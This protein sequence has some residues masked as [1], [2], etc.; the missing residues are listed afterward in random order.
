MSGGWVITASI[1]G[2]VVLLWVALLV[3]LWAQV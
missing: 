2:G 1:V 3:V